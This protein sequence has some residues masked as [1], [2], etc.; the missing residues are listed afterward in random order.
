[1][2]TSPATGLDDIC[3]RFIIN[4]PKEE[5]QSVERIIFQIEEGHWY[6]VPKPPCP[7]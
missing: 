5:F 7:R 3:V 2:L 6:A 1:L 4:L